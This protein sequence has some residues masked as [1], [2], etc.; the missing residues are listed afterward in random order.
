VTR[1]IWFIQV[2][3]III[4]IIIINN[5]NIIRENAGTS[6]SHNPIGLHGQLKGELYV[7]I[8]IIIIIIIGVTK[9]CTSVRWLFGLLKRI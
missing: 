9:S 1:N 8:I 2:S 5:N 4:I 3:F 6:T 7:I